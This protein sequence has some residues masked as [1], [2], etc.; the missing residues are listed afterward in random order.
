MK[1]Q[2][3]KTSPTPAKSRNWLK[4]NHA[5][6]SELVVGFRKRHTDEQSITWPEA[7]GEV[8]CFGWMQAE[9]VG[10]SMTTVT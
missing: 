9:I 6:T 10:E 2:P 1:G 5:T 8:L 3:R 4:V 7:V